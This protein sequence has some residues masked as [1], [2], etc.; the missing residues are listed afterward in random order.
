MFENFTGK[1]FRLVWRDMVASLHILATNVLIPIPKPIQQ[2]VCEQKVSKT[3][4]VKTS[5][6]SINFDKCNN[7]EL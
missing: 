6:I 2:T 1:R 4:Q 7:V 3:T 5:F